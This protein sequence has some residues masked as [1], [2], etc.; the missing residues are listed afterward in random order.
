MT[1]PAP[2]SSPSPPAGADSRSPE[3]V[4]DLALTMTLDTL[5]PLLFSPNEGAFPTVP[6][7][8][9]G[10][11]TS[12]GQRFH[13]L[14]PHARGGVGE[15]FVAYDEELHRE[16]A[17]KQVPQDHAGHQEIRSR[18]LL[19]AEITGSLEH[20]GVVP[21]Y[22]LGRHRDG[23]PF[24][25]M[26]FI[27]GRSLRQAIDSF[28]QAESPRRDPGERT[29]ALRELLGRF[30]DVC[31]TIA[32]AHSRGVLHRDLKPANI[33]LGKYGETLVVDWG[34]AKVGEPREEDRVA[35][36]DSA[37]ERPPAVVA[38]HSSATRVGATLG[39]PAF[40]SPEQARGQAAAVGPASDIYSLGA[41]LYML[42]T[43]HPPFEGTE[44]L[45]VLQHVVRGDF[46][47]PRQVNKNV[48]PPL[49][50]ICRKA[51][52]L[53]PE[54]RYGS[55]LELAADVRRWLADEPVSAYRE[56]RLARCG[57]W[58]RQHKTVVAAATAALFAAVLLG[59]AAA[60]L[61]ER[62]RVERQAE[63]DRQEARHR[64][65]VEAAMYEMSRLQ[66]QAR[67]AEARVALD[68]AESQ[69][70]EGGTQD[71][72]ER[73]EQARRDLELVV[74]LDAIRL[75]RATL[76]DGRLDKAMSEQD[77]TT[78]F[79]G[80]GVV[81]GRTSEEEAAARVRSSA[82]HEQLVASLDDWAVST[83]NPAL[84]TWLLGV[85]RR[86]DP[87]DWRDRFRDPNVHSDRSGLRGLANEL[88]RD[89]AK[90]LKE[91]SPQLLAAL[92]KALIWAKSDAVPLLTEAQERYPNDF[93]LNVYLGNALVQARKWGE[94][95]SYYRAA[96]AVRPNTAAVYNNLGGALHK[97]RVGGAIRAYQQA[98]DLDPNA[99]PTWNNFGLALADEGRMEKAIAAFRK[100][101]RLDPNYAQA[102][103]NL[104]IALEKDKVRME[105]VIP[106]FRK[107]VALDPKD[108][109]SHH[110][111]GFALTSL[112]LLDEA[113]GELEQA[114]ELDPKDT[115]TQG[116]LG[117]ALLA[118]GRFY[119]ARTVARRC[120]DLLP[121][122]HPQRRRTTQ[123]LQEC[124]RWIALEEKLSAV[125]EGRGKP[126]DNAERLA[127]A[128]LCLEH[129]NL[130]AAA[131]FYAEA[132]AAQPKLGDDLQAGHRYNAACAASLAAAGQG[133]D[134]AKL[135]DKE[136]T[137]LR[138]QALDWL[139]A[140]LAAWSKLVEGGE[141]ATRAA[142][143]KTLQHWQKDADLSGL[144]DAPALTKLPESERAA[145]QKLW[146]EV[147]ELLKN[148]GG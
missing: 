131:R 98:L 127:L 53:Q 27:R 40:M 25:A 97:G 14:R 81:A 102:H 49:D 58:M 45:V 145:C 143:V 20:P 47:P 32:Y 129:K 6:P 136:R 73:V 21:V 137:R 9:A 93:W 122:N 63:R 139:R 146:K 113:I 95:A 15:V 44:V 60:V 111:L 54:D 18:F 74:R 124:E 134:A 140:D 117:F 148:C 91:Q 19:E 42:L 110:A 104:G 7:A 3:V 28:H 8:G 123:L 86:A 109:K 34:L 130:P 69:L 46:P 26:R 57:R 62:Q 80:V 141:T 70:R 79:A 84:Q 87:D 68:Q 4:A 11:P 10:K 116:N 144:R 71:L 114:V 119:E 121:N 59:S 56:P 100:V 33:M 17:L 107:A 96:L 55:A 90:K 51:M 64:R 52:A 85:A 135:D 89:E 112:R 1:E 30:V 29:L 108:A 37:V 120:L 5:G 67:W 118:R 77:Y 105:E 48:P 94:A 133:I 23:R 22:G 99:A 13:V 75:K 103:Y 66:Q 78:A 16:V 128:R 115:Q 31:N 24:Y 41:T 36:Q 82:I 50:A 2:T 142:V 76:V 106:H 65:G 39:T 83:P 92:G 126:A 147:A 43:G 12:P 72:Q 132:F 38:V 125:L 138:K 61:L 88:L 35:K 101:I